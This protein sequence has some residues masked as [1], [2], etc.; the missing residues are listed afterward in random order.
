MGSRD[1]RSGSG[2]CD[3]SSANECGKGSG[4]NDPPTRCVRDHH[5]LAGVRLVE[6]ARPLPQSWAIFRE[7]GV[8]ESIYHRIERAVF[9]PDLL[10]HKTVN[11]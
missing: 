1:G 9:E 5:V 8:V 2:K 11:I 10:I 6:T 3:K 7:D 4:R